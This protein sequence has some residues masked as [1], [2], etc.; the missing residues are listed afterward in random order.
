MREDVSQKRFIEETYRLISTEGVEA[1]SIRR[2]G[3]EMG[4]N[5]AN[6]YH[7][8]ED[9]DELVTY[10][11]LRYLT[12]YLEDVAKCYEQSENTLQTYLM[13]WDCFSRH[14]FAHPQLFD[15]LFFGRHS[16][17]IGEIFRSYYAIFPEDLACIEPALAAVFT[18]G[19]FDRRDFLLI[20]RCAEDGWITREDAR[21]L[22]SLMIHLFMGYL[23]ELLDREWTEEE[24]E[25]SRISFLNCVRRAVEGCLLK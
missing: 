12:G 5:T 11:S 8:F 24:T 10:A 9:L 15:K 17:E 23:K 25:R 6:I 18:D 22:N 3:R 14:S 20:S 2:I 16:R 4:C 13:V 19:S 1:V 7:Y 21:Y